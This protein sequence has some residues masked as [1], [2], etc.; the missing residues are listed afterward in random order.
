MKKKT[1][2]RLPEKARKLAK[3]R[4]ELA[5]TLLRLTRLIPQIG[6]LENEL[7]AYYKAQEHY[8]L[9]REV[10]ARQIR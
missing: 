9:K 7:N 6:E 8:R 2:R 5:S 3:L 10:T 4:N 1:I